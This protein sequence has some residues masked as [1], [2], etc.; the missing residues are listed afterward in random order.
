[1]TGIKPP[2]QAEFELSQPVESSFLAS[3]EIF[4]K[5]MDSL[6]AIVYVADI[7]TH[8]IIFANKYLQETIGARE[9][10]ICWQAIQK[11]PGGPC[12]FC[13]NHLLV[14]SEGEPDGGLHRW[15][16]LN[17]LDGRWYD[18]I[19]RAAY[20]IDGR[21]VRVTIAT[22]ITDRKQMEDSLKESNEKLN[23]LLKTSPDLIQ[24]IDAEFNVAYTNEIVKDTLSKDFLGSSALDAVDKTYHTLFKKKLKEV[25]RNRETQTFQFK[26]VNGKWWES[27]IAVISIGSDSKGAMLITRN[28]SER[29]QMEKSLIESNEKLN[30]LLKNSPDYIYVIDNELNIIY[31]NEIAKKSISRD[32]LGTSILTKI[33]S[34]DKK[35]FEAKIVEVTSRR[36]SQPYEFEDIHKK[37][38]ESEIAPITIGSNPKCAMLIVRDISD[39]KKAEA[40][41]QQAKVDLEC[42]VKERTA[43]LNQAYDQLVQSEKMATLGFLVSGIAH[44]IN[45]PNSFIS[46]NIPILR[47]YLKEMLPVL[48]QHADANRSF[49]I[50]GME[51]SEFREDILKMLDNIEHGSQRI[52]K[53]VSNLKEYVRPVKQEE[54]Q[55]VNLNEVISTGVEL[56]RN[57]VHKLVKEF[58]IEIP[59][60]LPRVKTIAQSLEQILINLLINAAQA[61]DKP[62]SWVKLVVV[63]P[64]KNS[65]EL[66]IEVHDNGCGIDSA[67]LEKIFEPFYSTKGK[68]SGVG[69]GLNITKK[70]AE[71]IG[72]KVEVESESGVG[73]RFCLK[74]PVGI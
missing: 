46:F 34:K 36:I 2:G 41:M 63:K 9:G 49:E 14:N 58:G 65:E 62:D 18:M 60:D 55:I 50:C 74:I 70:L 48:D 35:Q 27:Q 25:I 42:R 12:D 32:I 26:D 68:K 72:G 53:T 21:L 15:E 8:E 29:K 67:D 52:T 7:K 69:L 64:P 38:W 22:D 51:Y 56:C 43:E 37:W 3:H 44:E 40:M 23:T 19:D 13:P 39:R 47:D 66:S 31:T 6:D 30:T 10:Q 24:V 20:W 54:F 17:P 5:V 57:K 16:H 59:D 71:E 33:Y 45:N 28:I 61:A 11:N 1:M 73:S 4:K